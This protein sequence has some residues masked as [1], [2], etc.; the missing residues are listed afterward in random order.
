MAI[1]HDENCLMIPAEPVVALHPSFVDTF[2]GITEALFVQQIYYLSLP[3]QKMRWVV[4]TDTDFFATTR[5]T[6]RQLRRLRDFATLCTEVPAETTVEELQAVLPAISTP[7]I[8]KSAKVPNETGHRYHYLLN[9]TVAQRLLD[10]RAKGANREPLRN[11]T[12][13]FGKPSRLTDG[14]PSGL[15]NGEPL[16]LPNVTPKGNDSSTPSLVQ[17]KEEKKRGGTRKTPP[18][19]L[20][21]F[22]VVP[23]TPQAALTGGVVGATAVELG[24][25]A[26]ASLPARVGVT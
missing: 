20:S 19:S 17:E 14:E 10:E 23:P 13:T 21:Q 16:G 26:P 12:L 18:A 9:R 25:G 3:L 2:G 1:Q 11:V 22:S 7:I 8:Y 4:Y 5:L 6:G 24:V 15:T